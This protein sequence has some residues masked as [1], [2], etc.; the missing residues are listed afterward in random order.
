MTTLV[1][2]LGGAAASITQNA[3]FLTL[4]TVLGADAL[5]AERAQIY[6]AIAPWAAHDADGPIAGYRIDVFA[7]S[8]NAHLDPQALMG[9]PALLQ[10][11]TSQAGEPRA[12]HGHVTQVERL[13]SDGGLARYRLRIEP[14]LATLAHRQD[15][16]VFQGQSVPQIVDELFADYAGQGQLAPIWRWDLADAAAYPARSLCV[17]YRETDLAFVERLLREEGLFYWFEHEGQP[18]QGLGLGQHTLVIADHNGAFKPN[19]QPRVRFTQAA[20]MLAEDS[21]QGWHTEA[22]LLPDAVQLA[23]RDYR[24]LG[25]RPVSQASQND[26]ATRLAELRQVDVPGAYAYEDTAQGDRLALRQ[27]Q[28]LDAGRLQLQGRGTVRT[29]APGQH[30][31]LCDHPEH[32][33]TEP[34]RDTFVVLN[35]RHTARSNLQ[36]GSSARLDQLL[37]GAVDQAVAQ[38]TSGDQ[39]ANASDAP[40][41]QCELRAQPLA[42][43]VRPAQSAHLNPRPTIEGSQTAIVVGLE[44]GDAPAV[45]T[46]RDHR[47]RVQFHWQ[48]GQRGSHRLDHAAG[49]NAPGTEAAGAWVRVAERQAGA[50]W[51][52]HFTPR[53]GQE[54]LLRFIGGD[55][56]RPLVLGS[57][58]NGQGQDEAQGNQVG[59]GPSGGT[60]NANAWFAGNEHTAVLSGF[61]TQALASSASGSGGYNQLVFDDSAGGNRMELA[62]TQAQTRLQMGHLLQQQ[63]NNLRL[64]ARGHGLDLATAAWGAVRAGAGLLISAHGRTASHAQAQQ[65]DPREPVGQL[66]RAQ[67]QLRA[68]AD[69]ARTHKASIPGEVAG[70]ALPA[71]QGLLDSVKAL[72]QVSQQGDASSA[73]DGASQ[74]G[75]GAVSAWDRPDLVVAAPAGIAQMTPASVL[76]SAGN[77]ASLVA[78]ADINQMAQGH[79]A[80]SAKD[81]VVLFTQGES[82]AGEQPNQETGIKLHAATGSVNVQAQTAAARLIADQAVDVSSTADQVRVGAPKHVLLAAAGAGIRLEGGNITLSAPGK[83]EFKA[84]SKVLTS[85]GSMSST[86]SLPV[87]G[88]LHIEPQGPFSIRPSAHGSD[89]MAVLAGWAGQPYRIYAANGEVLGQ[90]TVSANGRLDRLNVASS[91]RVVVEL[92]DPNRTDFVPIASK[93]LPPIESEVGAG[94]DVGNDMT[95]DDPNQVVKADPKFKAGGADEAL[96][97][98]FLG[99]ES[100]LSLLQ[101]MGIDPT[102]SN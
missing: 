60:G 36:S 32:D 29:M 93:S 1:S 16:W 34:T 85:G 27:L 92:G 101:Q 48:R 12:F 72:G 57:V 35:V 81:G 17:Q 62:T 66:Q 24:T 83:I 99:A 98:V 77:T 4:H 84:G 71:E 69:N 68:L 70:N 58:Y 96:K 89:D 50:N 7:F 19:A 41:Y 79:H 43:P 73:D 80:T 46:D 11:L 9:Q 67:S 40:L 30:F 31:S 10:M 18:G 90:G 63:D 59:A 94:Q 37:A 44:G 6:E 65:I 3:R 102:R 86:V 14:W 55:V 33:G 15:S 45:H 64:A 23:S 25:Q 100:A 97:D 26:G 56:D 74:G 38:A 53:V 91:D 87:P 13:G 2:L 39:G 75:T 82:P 28:A 21:L 5:L 76:W 8:E 52:G 20:A 54:V 51:G 61:K 47:I 49:S 22:Q 42:V 88:E 95:W 78:G